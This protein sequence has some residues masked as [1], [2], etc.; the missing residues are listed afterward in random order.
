MI[1]GEIIAKDGDITLNADRATVR[2]TDVRFV[3]PVTFDPTGPRYGL[4]TVY[5]QVDPGGMPIPRAVSATDEGEA[6]ADN[7]RG[8]G[9]QLAIVGL[10]LPRPFLRTVRR[11]VGGD[12][13]RASHEHFRIG[14]RTLEQERSRITA[15]MRRP[16]DA[17]R[18][19]A[20][21]GLQGHDFGRAGVCLADL[22]QLDDVHCETTTFSPAL[23][24][25]PL[26][27]T[28]PPAKIPAVTG[29]T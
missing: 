27:W 1:P 7:R 28:L 29:T 22:G 26:T 20:T 21:L 6:F 24:P 15:A 25:G 11:F 16:R 9:A 14:T 8:D 10:P 17:P 12:P 19:F 3:G 18:H 2:L 23:M 4:F 13:E 5:V